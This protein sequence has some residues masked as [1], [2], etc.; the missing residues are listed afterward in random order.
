LRLVVPVYGT[1]KAAPSPS[2]WV[3]AVWAFALVATVALG[4]A[5]QMILG[6]IR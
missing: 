3:T 1:T 4:L 6:G 2:P 5:V